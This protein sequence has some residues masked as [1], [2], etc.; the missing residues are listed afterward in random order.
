MYFYLHRQKLACGLAINSGLMFV[1]AL[2]LIKLICNRLNTLNSGGVLLRSYHLYFLSE[3]FALY[4]WPQMPLASF[5]SEP[6]RVSLLSVPSLFCLRCACA[7][8]LTVTLT[9]FCRAAETCT[10][11]PPAVWLLVANSWPFSPLLP[12][13]YSGPVNISNIHSGENC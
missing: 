9:Y 3:K 7:C 12:F 11:Y 8:R 4:R 5:V 10:L 2:F 6:Q 1:C 13:V